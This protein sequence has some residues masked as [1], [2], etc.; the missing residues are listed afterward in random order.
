M[1]IPERLMGVGMNWEL[2]KRIGFFIHPVVIDGLPLTLQGP[3]NQL[4][5]V[6]AATS[7]ITLGDQFDLG[8][9]VVVCAH[10]AVSLYPA[11][12]HYIWPTSAGVV[13]PVSADISRTFI[14]TAVSAWHVISSV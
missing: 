7:S 12:G 5:V 2:A 9:E 14:K 13:H 6:S 10:A 4:I 11:S 3:G 1:S 8:D